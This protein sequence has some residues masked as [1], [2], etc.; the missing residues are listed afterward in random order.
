MERCWST[1]YFLP[2]RHFPIIFVYS[3]IGHPESAILNKNLF[4]LLDLISQV[5]VVVIVVI[6]VVVVEVVE[7]VVVVVVVAVVMVVLL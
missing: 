4:I 7:P 1:E 5:V 2:Q 6:V 3:S